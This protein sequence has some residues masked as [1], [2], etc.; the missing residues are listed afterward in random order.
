MFV[1]SDRREEH[2]VAYAS[3]SLTKA[4]RNYSQIELEALSIIFGTRKF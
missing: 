4:E 3:K 1:P 2:P